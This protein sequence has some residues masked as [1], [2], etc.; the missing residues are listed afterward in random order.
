VGW[1]QV[2]WQPLLQEAP[3]CIDWENAI[4]FGRHVSNQ[5]D[6]SQVVILGENYR[7]LHVRVFAKHR[8]DLSRL[9]SEASD[10]DLMVDSSEEF[11]VAVP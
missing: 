8:L 6:A 1:N 11:N 10:L 2:R 5:L 9:D 7:R 4:L 3:Q